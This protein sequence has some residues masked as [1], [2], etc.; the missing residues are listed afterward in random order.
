MSDSKNVVSNK[1]KWLIAIITGLL[2]LLISSPFLYIMVNDLTSRVG[3]TVSS[4]SGCPT[5]NGLMI[6]AFV[7]AIIVRLLMR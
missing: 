3:V 7:F 2:F 6:H 1:D 5:M 4:P